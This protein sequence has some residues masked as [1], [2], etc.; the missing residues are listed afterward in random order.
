VYYS[1]ETRWFFRGEVPKNIASWFGAGESGRFEPER[2]DHYLEI[3]S[4][5]TLGV[6]VREGRLELKALVGTAG[7]RNFADTV[8]AF[9]DTWV[10]WSPGGGSEQGLRELVNNP[11][12]RWIAVRKKRCLRRFALENGE[13][14]EMPAA[15]IQVVPGCHAELTAVDLVS[16]GE[17]L[18]PSEAVEWSRA[19]SWWSLSLESFG[20][21]ASTL[22]NLDRAAEYFFQD[23][24]PMP[25]PDGCSL[26]YPAWLAELQ[27]AAKAAQ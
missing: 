3:P 13:V 14:K 5:R 8:T 27:S 19:D 26:S 16:S 1:G 7:V 17:G 2:T 25:L 12:D 9:R 4:C 23:P 18:V 21:P 22:G 24:P 20:D 11:G 10:K 6:K 15:A